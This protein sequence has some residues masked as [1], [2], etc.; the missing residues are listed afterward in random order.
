MALRRCQGFTRYAL[1]LQYH[2]QY[3]L[4]VSYQGLQKENCIITS[5]S[6]NET[7]LRGLQSIEGR[8]IEAFHN[9]A[10]PENVEN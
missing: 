10:G 9:L 8:L 6:K 5:N 4:G 7:D 3:H 2:G 1:S